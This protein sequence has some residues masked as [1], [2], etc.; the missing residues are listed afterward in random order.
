MGT[1]QSMKIGYTQKK[2]VKGRGVSSEVEDVLKY[3]IVVTS[4]VILRALSPLC[5]PLLRQSDWFSSSYSPSFPL[6]YLLESEGG[7]YLIP[8]FCEE[9]RQGR[10]LL[11]WKTSGADAGN[12]ANIT[13]TAL[14][15]MRRVFGH[16]PWYTAGPDL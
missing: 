12:L 7:G 16:D 5:F 2:S 1:K 14:T 6:G 13:I 4:R 3:S 15:V 8:F 10:N 9:N 11:D